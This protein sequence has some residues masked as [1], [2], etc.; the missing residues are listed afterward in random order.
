MFSYSPGNT[1]LR[2]FVNIKNENLTKI[3]R[4]L[5]GSNGKR[6]TNE[7]DVMSKMCRGPL[8]QTCVDVDPLL[9]NTATALRFINQI[10][11]MLFEARSGDLPPLA[12][13]LAN[14]ALRY[15]ET[16]GKEYMYHEAS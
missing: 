3:N 9:K 6:E 13:K 7:F 14:E 10:N 15:A 8:G 4:C 5:L 16:D 12:L 11:D 2:R 1:N